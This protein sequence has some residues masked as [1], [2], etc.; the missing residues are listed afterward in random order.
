MW[1]AVC[2]NHGKIG[3]G[4]RLNKVEILIPNHKD[5]FE[6]CRVGLFDFGD[7]SIQL[8]QKIIDAQK[9]LNAHS[10]MQHRCRT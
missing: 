4:D 10:N 6:D 3:K 5:S 7:T 8:G 9:K 1:Y 2:N